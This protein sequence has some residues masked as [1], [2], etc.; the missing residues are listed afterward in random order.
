MCFPFN[1]LDDTMWIMSIYEIK[2]KQILLFKFSSFLKSFSNFFWFIID[3]IHLHLFLVFL[4]VKFKLFFI[5]HY[6]TDLLFLNTSI[7][8]WLYEIFPDNGIWRAL[9]CFTFIVFLSV[10]ILF[11]FHLYPLSSPNLQL[12][13]V[14][15]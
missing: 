3:N 6:N 2:I 4:F 8:F 5:Q 15:F 12:H 10:R 14:F 7:F 1:L 11:S 9:S 13:F